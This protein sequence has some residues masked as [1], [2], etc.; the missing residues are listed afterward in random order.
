MATII[1]LYNELIKKG[2]TVDCIEL[3]RAH[4]PREYEWHEFKFIDILTSELLF[5]SVYTN[6]EVEDF[7][8]VTD[9]EYRM[10]LSEAPADDYSGT[11][12]IQLRFGDYSYAE[13]YPIISDNCKIPEATESN[14]GQA[15]YLVNK[16]AK[17]ARNDKDYAYTQHDYEAVA[18][19][20]SKELYMYALK[21][22]T[23]ELLE[24]EG[25]SKF[26]G[27]HINEY[28]SSTL[29]YY[30]LD[31]FTFHKPCKTTIEDEE[32][33]NA[34]VTAIHSSATPIKDDIDIDVEQ[35]IAILLEYTKIT[36]AEIDKYREK[37][38]IK[39]KKQLIE[40]KH[41]RNNA[42]YEEEYYDD[43]IDGYEYEYEC[44]YY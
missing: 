43:D 1:E 30:R 39:R 11:L 7:V 26:I 40:N 2:E 29:E 15:L 36:K 3:Y 6:V 18:Y 44:E 25:K 14:V 27:Y 17:K 21:D 24:S 19:S 37:E 33:E 23:L 16:E 8:L 34:K 32:C 12:L 20:K 35:A 42:N 31:K 5:N 4:S 28:N 22:K 9:E 38:E 13:Y 41:N 10:L